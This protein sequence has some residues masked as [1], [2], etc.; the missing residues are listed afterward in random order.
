MKK[1]LYAKRTF[2]AVAANSLSNHFCGRDTHLLKGKIIEYQCVAKLN[3]ASTM[4]GVVNK[5]AR[6]MTKLR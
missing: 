4:K 3:D 6:R 2:F 5:M 1:S